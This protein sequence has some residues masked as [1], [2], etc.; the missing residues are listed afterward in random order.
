M[1][2]SGNDQH[3]PSVGAT[4]GLPGANA[5]PETAQLSEE[6]MADT[7]SGTGSAEGP[8]P[9]GAETADTAG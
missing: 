7:V 2:A 4:G 6:E 1:T 9:T 3:A 5:A 8:A